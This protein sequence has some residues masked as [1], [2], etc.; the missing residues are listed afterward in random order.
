[1]KSSGGTTEALINVRILPINSDPT[2]PDSDGDGF[3]DSINNSFEKKGYYKEVDKWPL[4]SKPND[5]CYQEDGNYYFNAFEFP[6]TYIGGRERRTANFY[7]TKEDHDYIYEL[8][9]LGDV[10]PLL[11]FAIC[12]HE[13]GCSSTKNELLYAGYMQV[14]YEWVYAYYGYYYNG[15]VKD[16][17][18]RMS[19]KGHI[20]NEQKTILSKE[21]G[22]PNILSDIINEKYIGITLGIAMLQQMYMDNNGNWWDT[23]DTYCASSNSSKLEDYYYRNTFA[24]FI[25]KELVNDDKFKDP[26][27]IDY[28]VIINHRPY[29]MP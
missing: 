25:K 5:A 18:D 4:T 24:T 8:C 23:L 21:N 19:L 22:D 2:M 11:V 9:S 7:L 26:Q 3:L 27:N 10:D 15:K 16:I 17:I 20:N 29:R 6:L 12:A 28:F 13:S 1:M 14:G